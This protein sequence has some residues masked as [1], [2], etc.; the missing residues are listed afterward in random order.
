[1]SSLLAASAAVAVWF[2][3]SIL[4]RQLVLTADALQIRGVFTHNVVHRST[5]RQFRILSRSGIL[6]LEIAEPAADRTHKV[7]VHLGYQFDEVFADWFEG[8]HNPDVVEMVESI[9]EVEGDSV[10]HERIASSNRARQFARYFQFVALAVVVWAL[11]YPRPYSLVLLLLVIEPWLTLYLCWRYPLWFS[12]GDPGDGN[13]RADLT[14]CLFVPGAALALR[15]VLDVQLVELSSLLLPALLGL[16]VLLACILWIEPEYRKS[17]IKVVPL[18][19]L[20]T[21]YPAGSIA[22]LNTALDWQQPAVHRLEVLAK[23]KPEN[24]NRVRVPA[25]GPYQTDNLVE[26]PSDLYTAVPVG[27]AVC[28]YRYPGALGLD[29]YRIEAGDH[30]DR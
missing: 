20:L 25:W 17:W 9:R 26:V 27:G 2:I 4:K 12:V 30:C 18:A 28:L 29:W 15:A 22:L 6:E 8:L 13:V 23:S 16:L 5:I 14:L 11:L 1:V 21:A 10:S 7:K 3:A 19:L 24:S